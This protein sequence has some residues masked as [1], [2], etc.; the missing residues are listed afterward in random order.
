MVIKNINKKKWTINV[1]KIQKNEEYKQNEW[2]NNINNN[3][4]QT[5]K[6]TT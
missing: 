3:Y 1:N 6:W 2:T 5:K 4:I